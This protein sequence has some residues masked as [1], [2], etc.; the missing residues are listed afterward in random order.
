MPGFTAADLKADPAAGIRLRRLLR[1]DVFLALARG[2]RGFQ[3][4]SLFHSRKGLTTYPELVAAYGEVFREM[5]PPE[6]LQEAILFGERRDDVT[7]E[8]LAGP[9]FISAPET[10]DAVEGKV[11]VR[12][13]R[14]PSVRLAN[15]ACGNGRVLILVNSA[16]EPVRVRLGG[17]PPAAK[18]ALLSGGDAARWERTAAG[19][20]AVLE[21]FAALVL[22]AVR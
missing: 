21:P 15:L 12:K 3:V 19:L 13:D 5:A 4:W 1:H 2:A 17:I 6:N 22:R 8:V 14:W 10:L 9:A 11:D 16:A 20:E 7:I 18:L